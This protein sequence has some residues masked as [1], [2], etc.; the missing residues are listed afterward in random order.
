M[1]QKNLARGWVWLTVLIGVVSALLLILQLHYLAKI[2]DAVFIHHVTRQAVMT[3]LLWVLILIVLRAVLAWLKEIVGF[4]TSATIRQRL[5]RQILQKLTAL[6]P[7]LSQQKRTGEWV[8]CVIEQVEAMHGFFAQ[9]LPQM[10]LSVMV[11]LIIVAVVFSFNWLAGVI[12]L[13]T[14]PLIPLFMALVGMGAAAIN[15]KNFQALSRMSAHFLDVLQGLNTLKLFN[16][17]RQQ[18]EQVQKVS[19]D[20]RKTTMQTLRI[21]FLS[22]GVLEFFAACS[23]ALLATY[24]GL[25]LLGNIHIGHSV[26][27]YS[28][29]FILLLAP[30]FFL[31]LRELSVHYHARAQAVGA[32]EEIIKL[33]N[34]PHP[35]SIAATHPLYPSFVITFQQ[36]SF[37]YPTQ[38]N[39]ILDQV[40]LT[41]KPGE[42]IAIIG[43][44]GVGKSTLLNLL[45]GFL[46]PTTGTILIHDVA[47][48]VESMDAWRCHLGWLSQNPTLF[49]GSIRD[50]LLLAKPDATQTQLLQALE[51]AYALD[52]VQALPQGIDTLLGEQNLGL[53]GGQAQRIA[54][55]RVYLKNPDVLLLDE[56]T[57]SLDQDSQQLVMQS[58]QTYA[59]DKTLILLTHRLDTL[60]KMDRVLALSD[61]RLHEVAR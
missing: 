56:P 35:L 5:R 22:S 41:V 28:A 43:A 51:H 11:P 44:S 34:I 54:L 12:L 15:Q 31:P 26:D 7:I 1:Q 23:V 19:D 4:K 21:A 10:W 18:A 53:S 40:N 57:A 32:A 45:L 42:H 55:A 37:A 59:H 29:L 25:T 16:R 2:I 27:L 24:L 58:L 60:K 38:K 52:F 3:W 49:R 30:E 8:S 17:S 39:P 9:Y 14:A 36:V 61:G 13:V 46:Q 33:L 48:T 20:Y 6:G 47:L 50:N